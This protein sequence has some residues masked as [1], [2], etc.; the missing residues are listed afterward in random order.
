MGSSTLCMDA[1]GKVAYGQRS[2]FGVFVVLEQGVGTDGYKAQVL[3]TV[4][5]ANEELVILEIWVLKNLICKC[6]TF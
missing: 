6:H 4:E 3:V 1:C 5:R 2:V